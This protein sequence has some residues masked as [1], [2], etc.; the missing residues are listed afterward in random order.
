MYCKGDCPYLKPETS[1]CML[2]GEKLSHMRYSGIFKYSVYEH[3][4]ICVED[5]KKDLEIQ[6]EKMNER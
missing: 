6:R 3:N 1:R 5:L 2:T 4:G